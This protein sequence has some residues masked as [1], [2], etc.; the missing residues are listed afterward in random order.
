MEGAFNLTRDAQKRS[1]EAQIKVRGTESLTTQSANKR[2]ETDDMLSRYALQYN[3]SF[4]SNEQG[5][6]GLA[7]LITDLENNIP[8]VNN[9]V[10]DGRGTVTEC[11]GLC[12]GAGCGKCGGISCGEGAATLAA[13]ALDLGSKS[14]NELTELQIKVIKNDA[15]IRYD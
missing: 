10:C 11:D 9:M 7:R 12:G 15:L 4:S 14:H 13:N 6:A 1:T 5:L 8:Q 2:S 3:Q